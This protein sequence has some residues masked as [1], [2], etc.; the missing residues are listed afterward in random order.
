[1][2]TRRLPSVPL[3]PEAM[4]RL[5]AT[6]HIALRQTAAEREHALSHPSLRARFRAWRRQ[7]HWHWGLVPSVIAL[8]LV[9]LALC[10]LFVWFF[11]PVPPSSL[12]ARITVNGGTATIT[13]AGTGVVQRV[14]ANRS[15]TLAAGDQV[16][17]NDSTVR[18]QYLPQESS[19]LS[20]GVQA[21]L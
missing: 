5:R 13:R 10:L 17:T 7:T 16:A 6:V 15:D 2:F 19:T 14:A 9:L 4:R 3:S 20:P 8:D 21:T 1:Q 18:I 11:G 12:Q